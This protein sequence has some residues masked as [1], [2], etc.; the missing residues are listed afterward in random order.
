MC[1]A[2][3]AGG[4]RVPLKTRAYWLVTCENDFQVEIK[5]IKRRYRS[6]LIAERHTHKLKLNKFYGCTLLLLSFDDPER[7]SPTLT[8]ARARLMPAALKIHL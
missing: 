8:R 7:M 2:L 3:R 1:A 4:G 5:R 6:S